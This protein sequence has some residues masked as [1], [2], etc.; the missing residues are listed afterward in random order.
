M[1]KMF[2]LSMFSFKFIIFKSPF[3]LSFIMRDGSTGTCTSHM[4]GNRLR[5]CLKSVSWGISSPSLNFSFFFSFFKLVHILFIYDIK[6]AMENPYFLYIH[7]TR[8]FIYKYINTHPIQTIHSF[9]LKIQE[10]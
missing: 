10:R 6:D 5:Y 9:L 3:F 8:Y 1:V 4:K 2:I 7:Q